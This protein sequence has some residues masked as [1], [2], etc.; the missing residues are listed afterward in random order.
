MLKAWNIKIDRAA[1][2]VNNFDIEVARYMTGNPAQISKHFVGENQIEVHLHIHNEPPTILASLAGEIVHNLRSALDSIVFAIV[3]QKVPS[4]KIQILE[5]FVKKIHFPIETARESL[6]HIEFLSGFENELFYR[7]LESFQP[8]SWSSEYVKGEAKVEMNKG[9]HLALLQELSNNDKHRGI[10]I[11][12]CTLTDFAVGL[13]ENVSLDGGFTYS[14]KFVNN[15]PILWFKLQGEGRYDL[16]SVIP[17]FSLGFQNSEFGFPRDS[18]QNQMHTFL[19]Q[20]SY[21]VR[22]LSSH[23]ES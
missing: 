8:F 16:V 9:H 2:L 17:Q 21:Y 18:V 14:K 11:V 15:E 1:E 22:M 13:P 23:I 4:L 5:R 12:F 7:D 10:N 6:S 20:I 19:N 3:M